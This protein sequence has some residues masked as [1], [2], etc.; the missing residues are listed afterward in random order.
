MS[1]EIPDQRQEVATDDR[2]LEIIWF[3]F[4][5]LVADTLNRQQRAIEQQ[6]SA[7]DALTARVEAL[8]TP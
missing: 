5:E 6:Q 7:I 3:E 8:E 4:L 2:M 1:V